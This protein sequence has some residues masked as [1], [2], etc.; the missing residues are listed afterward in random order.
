MSEPYNDSIK[1]YENQQDKI[2]ALFE[3]LECCISALH[4][5]PFVGDVY[6]QQHSDTHLSAVLKI[7]DA[8]EGAKGKPHSKG[9]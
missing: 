3:A 9:L 1:A 8:L 2:D 5:V 6:D 4:N 7:Q